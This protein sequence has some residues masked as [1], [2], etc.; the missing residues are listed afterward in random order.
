MVVE[1]FPG[2]NTAEF[3]KGVQDALETLRPGLTG[4][5]TDTSW[6]AP[7]DYVAAAG[8]NLGL[9]I[10]LSAGLLL[11]TLL[12]LR[13]HWRAV[14]AGRITVPLSVISAA[15]VLNLLGYGINALVVAGLAAAVAI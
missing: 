3:T 2:A 10:A 15:L 9:A 5:N 1:K 14:L 11:L 8:D 13:F 6:F 12:V 4:I 7:S